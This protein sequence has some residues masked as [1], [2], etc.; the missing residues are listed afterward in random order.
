MSLRLRLTKLA[1]D[2]RNEGKQFDQVDIQ[3]NHMCLLIPQPAPPTNAVQR[4]SSIQQGV[5]IGLRS[6]V[7]ESTLLA[8]LSDISAGFGHLKSILPRTC[9]PGRMSLTMHICTVKSDGNTVHPVDFR[10]MHESASSD[11]LPYT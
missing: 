9:R 2:V 3:S 10:N 1:L 4:S 11:L 6:Q 7:D 8:R 5:D